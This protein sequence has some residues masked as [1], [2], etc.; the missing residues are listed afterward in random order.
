MPAIGVDPRMAKT[1]TAGFPA[2]PLVDGAV[3]N[4]DTF[5]H[6]HYKHPFRDKSNFYEERENNYWKTVCPWG[7]NATHQLNPTRTSLM[8]SRKQ[9]SVPHISYDIDGDGVVG[10]RDYFIGKS[11]D[12]DRDDRLSESERKEAIKALKNGWLDQFSF[13]HDQAGSKRPYPVVQR[14]GKIMTIDNGSVMQ[15]T[16]PKHWNAETVPKHTT[17]TEMANDRT[18]EL[19]MAANDK[20]NK[21]CEENPRL[22]YEQPVSQEWSVKDPPIKRISERAEAEHQ[23]ARVRAGLQPVASFVNPDREMRAPGLEYNNSPEFKS[24]RELIEVR[25]GLQVADLEAARRHQEEQYIPLSVR[26]SKYEAACT[27]FRA[28]QQTEKTLTQMKEQR[29]RE[30]IEYDRRHFSAPEKA[31]FRYSD[32]DQYWFETVRRATNEEKGVSQEDAD[33]IQGKTSADFARARSVPPPT[34][35]VTEQIPY[36]HD[37]HAP[38]AENIDL[39]EHVEGGSIKERKSRCRAWH[40]GGKTKW[41]YTTDVIKTGGLRNAAR[42]FDSM[43]PEKLSAVDFI[44]LDTYSSFE[45]IRKGA[46]RKHAELKAHTKD[47]GLKSRLSEIPKNKKERGSAASLS[48]TGVNSR[49]HGSELPSM[50]VANETRV[51]APMMDRTSSL[52]RANTTGH[53]VA[54][55]RAEDFGVRTGGFQR[56]EQ[57]ETIKGEPLGIT[58][59]ATLTATPSGGISRGASTATMPSRANVVTR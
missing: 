44:P 34:F 6:Q 15:E 59:K 37:T 49:S 45:V 7:T 50:V 16:Y 24:R 13:G 8:E 53:N 26:K 21:W 43:Q 23:Q 33:R 51:G 38:H 55:F 29:R 54:H 32:Q 3:P 46:M 27:K 58:Q 14:R 10:A 17:F 40:N 19:K 25:R 4:Y 56:L 20:I 5:G 36:A 28:S 42:L 47:H 12:K 1:F 11:F 35:K 30:R 52:W 57:V 39:P 22:V 41:K 2:R 9:Q 48:G 18:A 31:E